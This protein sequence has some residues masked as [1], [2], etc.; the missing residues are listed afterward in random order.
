[1]ISRYEIVQKHISLFWY[2][3]R[4]NILLYTVKLS[5][6]KSCYTLATLNTYFSNVF[7]RE[8]S[9]GLWPLIWIEQSCQSHYRK[10]LKALLFL[11]VTWNLETCCRI[12]STRGILKKERLKFQHGTCRISY[13]ILSKTQMVE[14][15]ARCG[16]VFTKASRNLGQIWQS[17]C[18]CLFL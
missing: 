6:F 16:F 2:K 17:W 12:L 13:A 7:C 3:E 5:L 4:R 18:D 10:I 14:N 15:L 8:R 11:V 9:W 1:M